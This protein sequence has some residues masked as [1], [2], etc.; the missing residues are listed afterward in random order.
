M[1]NRPFIIAEV[2]LVMV[3]LDLAKFWFMGGATIVN[4]Y[5][6]IHPFWVF[7]AIVLLFAAS[8]KKRRSLSNALFGLYLIVFLASYINQ[9]M[10]FTPVLTYNCMLF[11]AVFAVAHFLTSGVSKRNA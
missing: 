9:Y 1:K 7:L 10:D 5:S 11:N 8:G 2:V 4:W 3:I 6:A